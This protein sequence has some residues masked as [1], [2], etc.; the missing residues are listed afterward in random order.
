MPLKETPFGTDPVLW[1]GEEASGTGWQWR[2]TGDEASG[3][4][5]WYNEGT[6]ESYHPDFNNPKHPM[7]YDYKDTSGKWWRVYPHG[8]WPIEPK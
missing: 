2:G 7:H 4:G 8:D 1:G 3:R 6:G 5:S